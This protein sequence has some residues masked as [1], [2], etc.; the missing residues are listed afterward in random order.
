M[1][2]LMIL[3][4]CL[5][6]TVS[7]SWALEP[8]K[9][10]DR[11]TGPLLLIPEIPAFPN[12]RYEIQPLTLSQVLLRALGR[13]PSIVISRR[14]VSVRYAQ[15]VTAIETFFP[16]I[17]V[18]AG[19][20]T[21][22]GEVQN[23]QGHFYNVTKQNS[24]QTQQLMLS[25][26]PL[27]SSYRTLISTTNLDQARSFLSETENQKMA[28]AA[29][30]YFETLASYSRIAVLNEAVN[31]S[32][33][34][35]D[36]EKRL[37]ALGGA[38]IV[39]VLRAAHE[40]ARDTRFL[41]AEEN[42]AYLSSFR[43]AQI[44]G[45]SPPLLPTPGE[46]FIFPRLYIDRQENLRHLLELADRKRPLLS[47][48][49]KGVL[50]KKQSFQNVLFGPAFPTLFAGITNGALG[51]DFNAMTGMNQ[52]LYMA[53]WNLG[54]GGLLDP[55]GIYLARKNVRREEAV[56]SREIFAVHREVSDSFETVNKTREEEEVAL[57]DVRLAKLTFNAT[58]VRV[59]LGLFHALEL[60]ISLRDL[61]NAQLHYVDVVREFESAQFN[62]MAAIG[63]RPDFILSPN[64]V[65]LPGLSSPVV[66]RSRVKKAGN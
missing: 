57:E 25:L 20:M 47:A 13:S 55:G 59:R 33:L 22:S 60:I 31:I 54:P 58:Q 27:V 24:T 18:G 19:T 62:L 14:V 35:L 40:V 49:R 17:S 34:I 37:V 5:V 26:N 42:K 30:L 12:S 10:P 44:M 3:A 15:R 53:F 66:P 6:G 61:I 28:Q 16:T 52:A 50:S 32:K 65:A 43:L 64:P 36:E 48:Y 63:V 21:Y 8:I 4:L 29:S 41:V 2:K 9:S 7:D 11:G 39:G 1:K 23:S 45:E 56:L 38:S 46:R 51:P